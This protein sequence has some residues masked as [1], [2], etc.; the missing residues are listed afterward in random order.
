MTSVL[1]PQAGDVPHAVP[2]PVTRPFWDGCA[3]GRLLFQRCGR[4]GAVTFPPTEHCRECLAREQRW[5]AGSGRGT[6]Y[7]WS[8][9]HRPATPA[10]TPPYA[11]AVVTL[12]EGYQMV[13]N[14]IDATADRLRVD[15]PVRVAFRRVSD[16]LCLPYFV[17]A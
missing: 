7:S 8:I 1:R 16:E 14:I 12:E 13:T 5:E 17:P 9:V 3:E 15:L 6:L 2:G 10:F 11:A 4:C